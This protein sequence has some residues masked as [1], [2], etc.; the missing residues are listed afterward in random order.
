MRVLLDTHVFL[1]AATNSPR[2]SE[3]AREQLLS[4]ERVYVSAASVWEIAIK[5]ALG[6]IKVDL[7]RMV[8]SIEGSGFEELPVR[9]THAAQVGT[10]PPYHRDPFDR[11]LVAQA[12]VEPLLLLTGDRQLLRY[13]ELVRLV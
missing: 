7:G 12:T 8:E 11:L 13:S 6:R 9:A 3:R 4:A 10:L 2:L 5:T 1:W